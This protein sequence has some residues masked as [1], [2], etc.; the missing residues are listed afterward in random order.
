MATFITEDM[1]PEY[2]AYL[3]LDKK[4]KEL[5][6]LKEAAR[7]KILALHDKLGMDEIVDAGFKSLLSHGTRVTLLS[8]E[9]EKELGKPIPDHCK[10]V[11]EYDSLRVTST[12]IAG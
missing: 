7:K 10:K 1:V 11:T 3:E 2:K 4:I 8:E 12:V 6:S 5:T 9:I